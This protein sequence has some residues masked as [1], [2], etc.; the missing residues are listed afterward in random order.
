MPSFR[1]L[2]CHSTL[3][4]TACGYKSSVKEYV[5]RQKTDMY[6]GVIRDQNHNKGDGGGG[7]G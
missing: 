4:L 7:W 1:R 3:R 2:Q 6:L 5:T